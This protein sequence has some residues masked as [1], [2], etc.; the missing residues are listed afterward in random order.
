MFIRDVTLEIRDRAVALL[1]EETRN[2][3]VEMVIVRHSADAVAVAQRM[4]LL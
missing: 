4:K 3:G 1:A 2:A